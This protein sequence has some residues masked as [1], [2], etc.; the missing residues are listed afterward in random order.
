MG[1][2]VWHDGIVVKIFYS[3]KIIAKATET[4]QQ[5]TQLP[6]PHTAAQQQQ[7]VCIDGFD[8]LVAKAT[9][10]KQSLRARACAVGNV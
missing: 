3:A 4:T 7:R 5:P 6:P 10:G 9:I 2:L 1:Q 8:E